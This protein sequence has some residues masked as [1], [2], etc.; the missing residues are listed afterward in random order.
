MGVIIYT[1]DER[2]FKEGDYIQMSGSLKCPPT[3]PDTTYIL[4]TNKSKQ[5]DIEGWMPFVSYRLVIV[6]DK[7]P[8]LSNTFQEQV[9]IHSSLLGK[10]ENFDRPIQS[11][12]RFE[13]RQRVFDM[14]HHGKL[15]VPLALAWVRPNR[16]DDMITWRRLA[17]VTYMLPEIYAQAVL[18]YSIE[19]SKQRVVYPKK[20]KDKIE[21]P[22]FFRGSDIY[23]NELIERAPEIANKVRIQEPTSLPPT[24]KKTQAKIVEWI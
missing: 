22:K 9:I 18:S 14:I 23:A 17:K 16:K 12:F 6:C 5:K 20:K 2:P 19:P 15:P 11:M 7:L 3:A 21:I 8:R 10:K 1:A 24:V 13:D 4:F